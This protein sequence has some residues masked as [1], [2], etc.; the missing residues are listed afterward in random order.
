MNDTRAT[1]SLAESRTVARCFAKAYVAY[2][3]GAARGPEVES[4]ADALTDAFVDAGGNMTEL[5]ERVLTS[6]TLYQRS[7]P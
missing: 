1:A 7:A 5:A 6:P 4:F 2:T 3:L